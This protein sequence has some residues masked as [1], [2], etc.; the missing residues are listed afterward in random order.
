VRIIGPLYFQR[1]Y[2]TSYAYSHW[3][4][5]RWEIHLDWLF[6]ENANRFPV[7]QL[8]INHHGEKVYGKAKKAAQAEKP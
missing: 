6:D 7:W 1:R 4:A 3:F 5:R 2:E 8:I